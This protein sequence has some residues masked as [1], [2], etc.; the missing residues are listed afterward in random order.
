MRPKRTIRRASTELVAFVWWA[1]AAGLLVQAAWAGD[2]GEVHLDSDT[3]TVGDPISV[4][5][6]FQAPGTYKPARVSWAHGADTLLCLDS[7]SIQVQGDSNWLVSTRVALFIPGRLS[8]GPND[9]LLLGP[10][11]DSLYV[12]FPPESVSVASVLPAQQ[13]SIP[14]APYKTLIQPPSRI[15]LWVWAGLLMLAVAVGALVYYLRRPK[16]VVVVREP[17]ALPPWDVALTRLSELAERKHHLRGEPRPFAI[18]LSE[19]VRAYLEDRYGI[20]ALEQTTREIMLS[21]KHVEL[22][23]AQREALLR[24][25]QGCDLAKYANFHWPAP[26]LAAS[27]SAARRFVEA[28]TPVVLVGQGAS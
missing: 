18:A 6:R 4:H 13:D 8:A 16:P 1:L 24:L 5:M 23:E 19:I 9:I 7:L 17:A 11:G 12:L 14:A 27:L 28:T 25:L 10:S 22:S 2:L 3:V 15:S 21:L 20:Y 26:D